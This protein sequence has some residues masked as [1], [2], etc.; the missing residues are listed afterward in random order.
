MDPRAGLDEC[1]K[2]R[3]PPRLDPRIVHP[4]ASRY[5][6]YAIP[7][8]KVQWYTT[9][10]NKVFLYFFRFVTTLWLLILVSSEG[11]VR[12]DNTDTNYI[13]FFLQPSSGL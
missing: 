3:P 9:C 11:C 4:V 1:G 7:A 13:F 2:S 10:C 12:P 8:Y 6:D 5:T